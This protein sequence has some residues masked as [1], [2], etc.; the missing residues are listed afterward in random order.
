LGAKRPTDETAPAPALKGSTEG[1]TARVDQAVT[2]N[3]QTSIANIGRS[4]R[5]TQPIE[6]TKDLE[7]RRKRDRIL[8]LN[9]HAFQDIALKEEEQFPEECMKHLDRLVI[10]LKKEG[11][12]KDEGHLSF[13]PC[14]GKR[15]ESTDNPDTL[16]PY[17]RIRGLTTHRDIKAMNVVLSKSKVRSLY[18][19]PI[20]I[21]YELFN[22]D[23][24]SSF[25][26]VSTLYAPS[27]TLCGTLSVIEQE[28]IQRTVTIGG[29]IK[30]ADRL[31]AITA[32]HTV[33][34]ISEEPS[35]TS[36]SLSDDI[37]IGDIN[38]YGDDVEPALV[39]EREKEE[40][41]SHGG[42]SSPTF[43]STQTPAGVEHE[44]SGTLG[45]IEEAGLEWSL[46]R[47][48]NPS[49]QLPNFAASEEDLKTGTGSTPSERRY[50][51]IVAEAPSSITV[52]VLAGASGQVKARL[53]PNAAYTR[54]PSGDFVQTWTLSFEDGTGK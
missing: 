36:S 10:Y 34:H 48:Q 31:Y 32:S 7:Y 17:I 51:S 18:H 49:L 6:N 38:D 5:P 46:I 47:I 3:S 4:T 35:R 30:V 13:I 54:L 50:I 37:T 21:C 26:A 24:S 9:M 23:A 43:T 29:L 1:K 8:S 42:K 40:S 11:G 28:K 53:L 14:M 27:K 39:I 25:S 15:T 22:V 52:A 12:F 16:V 33:S 41:S 2:S 44:Y 45:T 19:P 20:R